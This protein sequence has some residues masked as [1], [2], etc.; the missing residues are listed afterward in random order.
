MELKQAIAWLEEFTILRTSNNWMTTNVKQIA[1]I[2][3]VQHLIGM[4]DSKSKYS[5]TWIKSRRFQS[6][7]IPLDMFKTETW[8]RDRKQQYLKHRLIS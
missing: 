3:P 7:V 5:L 6:S 1:Y 4:E 8:F 2:L